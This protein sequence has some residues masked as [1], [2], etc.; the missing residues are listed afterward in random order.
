MSSLF[1]RWSTTSR[2]TCVDAFAVSAGAHTH[3]PFILSAGRQAKM[4][5]SLFLL[6]PYLENNSSFE[7]DCHHSGMLA[8]SSCDPCSESFSV[9][10]S[11]L[12]KYFEST[13]Y[14]TY[15]IPYSI[16]IISSARACGHTGTSG[17]GASLFLLF[18]PSS[19][20]KGLRRMPWHIR[21][22]TF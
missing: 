8:S 10:S 12:T 16:M 19:S 17:D 3:S 7:I 14:R 9:E 22:T 21:T 18:L 5:L 6:L 1:E 13:T 11:S 2:G 15:C 20:T 4:R